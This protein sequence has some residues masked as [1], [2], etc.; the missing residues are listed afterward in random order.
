MRGLSQDNYYL[1]LGA[2]YD[3]VEELSLRRNYR[4]LAK[5][6]HPDK[7][8]GLSD[9]FLRLKEALQTLLEGR[10]AYDEAFSTL[11]V[12]R[13]A[14]VDLEER[15]D[16]MAACV[17]WDAPENTQ[18][19][20]R[21]LLLLRSEGSFDWS[22]CLEGKKRRVVIEKLA[23]G[24]Y[25]LAVCVAG[26]PP[27]V[28]SFVIDDLE[29]QRVQK[30]MSLSGMTEARAKVALQKH[31]SVQGALDQ[32]MKQG[33]R[34]KKKKKKKIVTTPASVVEEV[35]DAAFFLA[36]VKCSRCKV[37]IA[38]ELVEQHECL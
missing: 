37:V 34:R 13:H 10:R 26:G 6:C 29:M 8:D 38:L 1:L 32:L 3:N 36:N 35:P 5:C 33:T 11:S 16:S 18:H 31:G 20:T 21:F 27:C 25:E 2:S 14:K 24:A 12:P 9:Q 7:L 30:L 4:R 23:A 15:D 19:K 28:V 22:L 17:S